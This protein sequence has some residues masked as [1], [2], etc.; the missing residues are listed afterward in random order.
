M[1]NNKDTEMMRKEF[2]RLYAE[3]LKEYNSKRTATVESKYGNTYISFEINDYMTEKYM[4]RIIRLL[5]LMDLKWY[6]I[7]YP[8]ESLQYAISIE[9]EDPD[10]TKFIKS[11]IDNGYRLRW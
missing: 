10:K 9:G 6:W 8:S 11:F 7:S 4:E 1:K 2:D 3:M 5:E